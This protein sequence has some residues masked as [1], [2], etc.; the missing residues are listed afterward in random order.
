M[1]ENSMEQT[2]LLRNIWNEMKQLGANLGA[3]IDQT[4]ARLEQMNSSL[5]ERIDQ[6]NARLEGVE[7]RL[8]HVEGRLE[9]MDGRLERMDGRLGRV[10]ESLRDLADQ[11][12]I[13]T[14]VLA[15]VAERHDESLDDLRERVTRL[16]TKLS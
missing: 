8:E 15:N 7:N 14:R 16:E 9:R 2:Q 6:T 3:R 4:N 1:D 10:E 12:L 11:Q 13:L 5:G